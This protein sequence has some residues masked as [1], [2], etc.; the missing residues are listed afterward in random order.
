MARFKELLQ[1]AR[2]NLEKAKNKTY[3]IKEV[4][5]AN[6]LKRSPNADS[7]AVSDVLSYKIVQTALQR[8]IDLPQEE[9]QRFENGES[10]YL[11]KPTKNAG[12]KPEED[13]TLC[14]TPDPDPK[15]AGH[16]F[17]ELKLKD[18]AG[19]PIDEEVSLSSGATKTRK[20]TW[21][22]SRDPP[23][24]YASNTYF[25]WADDKPKLQKHDSERSTLSALAGKPEFNPVM[26]VEREVRDSSGNLLGTQVTQYSKFM[27]YNLA[28]VIAGKWEN[29]KEPP[30]LDKTLVAFSGLMV[31]QYKID[32]MQQLIASIKAMHGE[33]VNLI[34]ADIKPANILIDFDK[35]GKPI[36][37]MIDFDLS[38]KAG[39]SSAR[40]S[41]QHASPKQLIEA[42][43][44][45]VK[46]ESFYYSDGW[47]AIQQALEKLGKQ[48]TDSTTESK[49]YEGGVLTVAET[50]QAKMDA[51]LLYLSKVN[52]SN[53]VAA[54]TIEAS[55]KMFYKNTS[56]YPGRPEKEQKLIDDVT[57]YIL[58]YAC[59]PFDETN[60]KEYFD[61]F[62][63]DLEKKMKQCVK[64]R[65]YVKSIKHML[66]DQGATYGELSSREDIWAVGV[67]FRMLLASNM[68]DPIKAP[69]DVAFLRD[70]FRFDLS[71]KDA[72]QEIH[73]VD[74][75]Q[76]LFDAHRP[77]KTVV[78]V[79]ELKR[80]AIVE[81]AYNNVLHNAKQS[82]SRNAL[83]PSYGA[84][85]TK[86]T[87]QPLEPTTAITVPRK[88]GGH[89]ERKV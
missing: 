44:G 81:E 59:M 42:I 5:D 33:G 45:D 30:G 14:L 56:E 37:K 85:T 70:L 17:L 24:A 6:L 64:D 15:V 12:Y 67:V 36:V 53:S 3:S 69:K 65:T 2:V 7:A 4:N 46:L 82:A 9:K 76:T 72:A 57:N 38:A 35:A 68:K 54:T 27:P 74:Q 25:I 16:I 89:G 88:R 75:L 55:I 48:T 18:A 41:P 22:I 60:R 28:D 84:K 83:L 79:A 49:K 58:N 66:Q 61:Y 11:K 47:T 73:T 87:T 32:I 8:V 39:T 1:L 62:K 26:I 77:V 52:S 31:E 71:G 51:L 40:G 50:Q 63:E 86:P 43:A 19:N 34:H 10:V 20:V 13:R 29:G 23:E 21:D 80:I 78:N